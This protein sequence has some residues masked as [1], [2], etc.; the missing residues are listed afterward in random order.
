MSVGLNFSTG[1]PALQVKKSRN[2]K[3]IMP[4][5][6]LSLL[7]EHILVSEV[8]DLLIYFILIKVV[9]NV[10]YGIF[11]LLILLLVVDLQKIIDKKF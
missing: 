11:I 1:F 3:K 5:I 2:L 9:L 8:F 7:L 6:T 10:L 4:F